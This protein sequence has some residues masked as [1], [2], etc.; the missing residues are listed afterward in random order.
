M[1]GIPPSHILLLPLSPQPVLPSHTPALACS[2]PC[3]CGWQFPAA[4]GRV[5]TGRVNTSVPLCLP[6]ASLRPPVAHLAG[7]GV[8]WTG[9]PVGAAAP[10]T[11]LG[12]R[13]A[14]AGA[15]STGVKHRRAS[16]TRPCPVSADVTSCKRGRQHPQPLSQRWP[17]SYWPP[18]STQCPSTV[19]GSLSLPGC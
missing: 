4:P 12:T 11:R 6:H 18:I 17:C 19:L 14:A 2:H 8:A 9:G 15:L 16:R 13:L 7:R 3:S 10:E 5:T 1:R